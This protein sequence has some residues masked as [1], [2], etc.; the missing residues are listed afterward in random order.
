VI[1]VAHDGHDRRAGLEERLVVFFLVAEEGL[2]LEFL[3]LAGLDEENLGAEGLAPMSSIISSA[4]V[5]VPVTIS[6]ASKSKRTRSA[7]LRFSFGAS[8]WIV[9]PRGTTISPTGTGASSGVSAVGAAGPRSSKSR[10]RRFL[11]RGR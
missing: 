9:I 11:R 2:Q 8:S 6:P 3:L 10:R 7:A 5:W 4:S 1:D